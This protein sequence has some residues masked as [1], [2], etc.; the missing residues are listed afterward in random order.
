MLLAMTWRCVLI[1]HLGIARDFN[2]SLSSRAQ[3]GNTLLDLRFSVIASAAWRSTTHTHDTVRVWTATS[4]WSLLAVTENKGLASSRAQRGDLFTDPP[5]LRD[6]EQSVAIHLPTLHFSVIASAA[7]RSS[8]KGAK[9]VEAAAVYFL[10]TV[11][12]LPRLGFAFLA[13]TN[14]SSRAQR[15]DPSLRFYGLLL[16]GVDC[17][18]V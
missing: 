8:A 7:W 15:G 5:L 1:L 18:V 11:G 3:R 16:K 12:G 10:P 17:H 4:G 6:R 13:M 2:C 9:R 14:T